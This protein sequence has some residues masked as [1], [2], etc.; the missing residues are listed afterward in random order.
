VLASRVIDECQS[1]GVTSYFYCKDGDPRKNN[2]LAILKGLLT[3][4][5]RQCRSMVPYCDDRAHSNG[6]RELS[7]TTTAK[8]ILEVFCDEIQKQFIIIDGLDECDAK[9]RTLLLSY[10]TEIANNCDAQDPGKLR[11]LI[12][13]QDFNDIKDALTPSES[14]VMTLRLTEE[15]NKHEIESFV[16]SQIAQMPPK[17][18]LT[19]AE[20]KYIWDLVCVRANGRRGAASD[21]ADF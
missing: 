3:H 14:G 1:L 10:L 4:M 2:C 8:G 6:Q 18:G 7:S 17:F 16:T 5:V 13:S 19:E 20:R 21:V 9:E 15:D 11:L 12:V